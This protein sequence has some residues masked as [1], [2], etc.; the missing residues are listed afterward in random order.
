M[1]RPLSANCRY[2]LDSGNV[3]N[4]QI[5][6]AS[7]ASKPE[8]TLNFARPATDADF[9]QSALKRIEALSEIGLRADMTVDPAVAR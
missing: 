4:V 9:A 1:D 2:V 6:R 5:A 3:L 7:E 8:I